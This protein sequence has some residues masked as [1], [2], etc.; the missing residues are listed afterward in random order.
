MDVLFQRFRNIVA[1]MASNTTPG[2]EVI[3]ERNVYQEGNP[4]NKP[5]M[6]QILHQ[7][8][9]PGS[10]INGFEN[11]VELARRA[12]Y[13]ENCLILMEHYSNFDIPCFYELLEERGEAG[14]EVANRIVSI[15]GSKLNEENRFVRAF[16][17]IFTRIVIVPGRSLQN[18]RDPQKL[19]EEDK[20]RER[21]N[22]AAMRK[23]FWLRKAGR[24][25]LVFPTGTR[26]RPWDPSTGRGLKE[27]DSYVKSYKNMVLVAINGNILL[28]TREG[29][30][31]DEA[32]QD[33]MVYTASPV[34]NC[35]EYRE[36]ALAAL[37]AGVDPK[38][39]VIDAV[40]EE[41]RRI[42]QKTEEDRRRVLG[43]P[44]SRS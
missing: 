31:F 20:R 35:R 38:Q 42:H 41:L 21:I 14:R 39:Q 7:L 24:I 13:R 19:R 27:V 36:R 8:M 5:L 16:T 17:E 37:P 30:D 3:T 11:L 12:A 6:Q 9:L 23:L 4:R 34:Y 26:Y 32:T 43:Q 44:P 28:P 29:M 18:I 40:M 22:K 25:I 10:R 15:A 33:I 2:N 1:E